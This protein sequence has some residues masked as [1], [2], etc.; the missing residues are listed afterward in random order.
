M[1]RRKPLL[2]A[3]AILGVPVAFATTTKLVLVYLEESS[4]VL[5]PGYIGLLTLV[6]LLCSGLVALQGAIYEGAGWL[7]KVIFFAVYAGG[8]Y[9][10]CKVIVLF[11]LFLSLTDWPH[12]SNNRFERSRGHVF[13]GP[14]RESMIGIKCLRFASTQP[15]VAQPHR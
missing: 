7:R 14:G 9:Y 10:V 4:S 15:R 11:V 8:M 13:V 12:A 3:W 6:L 2:W 5:L 1:I